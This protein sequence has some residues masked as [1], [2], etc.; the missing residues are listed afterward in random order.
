MSRTYA[1]WLGSY[2][3]HYPTLASAVYLTQEE[4]LRHALDAY[5][6]ARR[7]LLPESGQRWLDPE[8]DGSWSTAQGF[9]EGM[10]HH[11]QERLRR[12]AALTGHL[13]EVPFE[14]EQEEAGDINCQDLGAGRSP[15]DKGQGRPALLTGGPGIPVSQDVQ[16]PFTKTA[17]ISTQESRP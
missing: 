15:A 9:Y 6:L 11:I 16:A 17:V 10:V 2:N 14:E 3:G 1:T 4:F 7:D 5:N 12:R 13:A 8:T